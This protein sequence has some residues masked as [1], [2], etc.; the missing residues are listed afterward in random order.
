MGTY[1]LYSSGPS[2][3]YCNTGSAF[4]KT[5]TGCPQYA[6]CY[7]GYAQCQGDRELTNGHCVFDPFKINKLKNKIHKEAESLLSSLRGEK[8]CGQYWLYMDLFWGSIPKKSEKIYLTTE[9]LRAELIQRM[10]LN[11]HSELFSEAFEDFAESIKNTEEKSRL[12]RKVLCFDYS[13]GYYSTRSYHSWSCSL[14]MMLAGYYKILAVATFLCGYL[15]I[16]WVIR[17]R[18]TAKAQRSKQR[19]DDGVGAALKML[20]DHLS[21]G[22]V[23]GLW[24]PITMVRARVC[25]GDGMTEKEWKRVEAKVCRDTYVTQSVQMMDGL[26]QD[27]WKMSALA[28]YNVDVAA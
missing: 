4:D 18:R 17:S 26:Q 19:V 23:G 15:G 6:E 13:K 1:S 14:V 11:A 16:L 2:V 9:A 24:I 8:E 28:S 20:R 27:C 25:D 7:G 10:D 12:K 22:S 5:C 21:T 3:T